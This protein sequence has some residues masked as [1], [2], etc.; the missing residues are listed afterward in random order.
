M[1]STFPQ[2]WVPAN[3]TRVLMAL[4]VAA[5]LE[6]VVFRAGL[7]ETLLR[8]QP[9][10]RL[11]AI[12]GANL[13][14]RSVSHANLWIAALFALSHALS[15]SLWLGLGSFPAAVLLGAVYERFRRVSICIA[16]HMALNLIWFFALARFAPQ[17]MLV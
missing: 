15:R 11:H 6:E 17:M 10:T 12:F 14:A 1:L 4:M 2:H 13:P 7:H 16:V 9:G 3:D 8:L 5:A